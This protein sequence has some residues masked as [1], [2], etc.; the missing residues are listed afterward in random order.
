[1]IKSQ[2]DKTQM[3]ET[4]FLLKGLAMLT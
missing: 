4:S 2:N 3:I 1:M